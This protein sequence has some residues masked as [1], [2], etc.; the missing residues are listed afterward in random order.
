M[1]FTETELKGAYIV[2][3]ERREDDRGFFARTWCQQEFEA[4]GLVARIVQ[5]NTS[6][7]KR[8]GTLRGMHYQNAPFAETK[9][10]R[11]V[12]GAIYDVI[13]DLRPDSPTYRRWIGV[14]LTADNRRA[15][16]VPEGFAHG[17]QTLEDDT[18]VAYQV[19]AFYTPG[20]EGGARYNDP[21]FDIQWPLPVSVISDKDAA[22]PD[23]AG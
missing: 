22:W 7:N 21:A 4:H 20:A 12:R 13:V 19:S 11:A 5:A 2:D 3:I 16:F 18:D 6:Y 23:F 1:I 17:F 8:K 10:V 9:L 14:E 15:L